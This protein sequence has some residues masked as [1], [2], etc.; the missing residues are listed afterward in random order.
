MDVPSELGLE[1]TS[2]SV[3]TPQSQS[4]GQADGRDDTNSARNRFFILAPLGPR[5]LVWLAEEEQTSTKLE[6]RAGLL[7]LSYAGRSHVN[8]AR[9]VCAWLRRGESGGFRADYSS[10][11]QRHFQ[12]IGTSC[13]GASSRG[14]EAA[15]RGWHCRTHHKGPVSC[16]RLRVN[17]LVFDAINPLIATI[18]IERRFN[19]RGEAFPS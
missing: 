5:R 13:A 9:Q 4:Q 14:L 12:G 16:P 1:P 7:G 8:E 11:S 18:T 3:Y 6:R 15:V 10:T 2:V 19:L 17:F